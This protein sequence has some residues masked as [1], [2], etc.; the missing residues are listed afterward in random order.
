MFA[1]QKYVNENA[2]K[3]KHIHF[4]PQVP[5]IIIERQFSNL[6]GENFGE[7][8]KI[9]Q[10]AKFVVAGSQLSNKIEFN[11]LKSYRGIKLQ[12]TTS[13]TRLRICH[14]F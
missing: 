14:R 11:L 4:I 7:E 13:I 8:N 5:F 1:S 12:N 3:L 6:L 9:L 2:I 10:S